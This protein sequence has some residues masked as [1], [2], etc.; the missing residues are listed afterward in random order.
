MYVTNK[1]SLLTTVCRRMADGKNKT[2]FMSEIASDME[3]WE[4]WD[5]LPIN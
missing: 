3:E 1:K 2:S 4:G 5:E